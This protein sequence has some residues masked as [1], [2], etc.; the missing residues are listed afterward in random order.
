M[1]VSV[2]V[3]QP[4][5]LLLCVMPQDDDGEEEGEGDGDRLLTVRVLVSTQ[6]TVVL[7]LLCL[8]QDDDDEEEGDGGGG[9]KRP[10]ASRFI[11]DIAAVDSDEEEEEADVSALYA[12]A[13]CVSL[14]YGGSSSG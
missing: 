4:T 7:L 5:G 8:P 12:A 13:S 2:S 14:C 10:K 6:Q 1:H 9:R 11:D 3:H